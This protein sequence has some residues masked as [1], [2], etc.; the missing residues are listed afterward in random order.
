MLTSERQLLTTSSP[1]LIDRSTTQM[2]VQAH[3]GD[4]N[5]I[6]VTNTAGLTI[7]ATCGRDRT[8]QLFRKHESHLDLL[9]TLDDHLA[10]VG[11]VKFLDRA[12]ILS[13]SSDRTIIVRKLALGKEQSVAFLPIRVI[14]LK[15]SPV[16]LTAVPA[17]P[18]VV[19][20]STLDRQVLRYNVYSGRLLHSFKAS[21]PISG[22]SVIMSSLD[23]H[24]LDDLTT[25]T[26]LLLGVSS[27]DKSI[28]IHEYDTGALL[29][30]EY[31][32]NSVSAIKLLRRF[33][34]GE[35]PRNYLISCSLDGTVM[36]WG[37]SCNLPKGRGSHDTPIGEESPPRH[38]LPSAQP[39]RRILSKAEILDF[40][41]SLA[42]DVDTLTPTQGSTPSRVRRKT[43]RYDSLAAAPKISSPV[44]PYPV[45]TSLFPAN[46]R[47]QCQSSQGHSPTPSSQKNT[48]S[49]RSKHSLL[50]IRPRSK[51][52]ENL[53]DL[54]E[55]G[56]QMCVSLRTFRNRI[57][58]PSV[59]KLKHGTLQEL[60]KQLNLTVNALNDNADTGN[61]GGKDM[62]S[63][64]LD[65]YLAKM[66]DERLAM[67][68]K[69]EEIA[70]VDSPQSEAKALE[71]LV[72][73]S[74]GGQEGALESE[75]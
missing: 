64:V 1:S 22:N 10:A 38:I 26:R 6:A 70:P 31:G 40:R 57:T 55:L 4:I 73:A 47:T 11:D 25:E 56:E 36:T 27:T 71:E 61:V 7:I 13:I 50:D 19:L 75:Q 17:E 63:D 3:S 28:R 59:A 24:E 29:I 67:K 23:V 41:K 68:A 66:I 33:V 62:G 16:S 72:S 2:V 53:N 43:S 35:S 15:A 37:L 44:L 48:L 32:Q 21:D 14:T 18:N 8:L 20:V 5:G 9:Q 45:G 65:V 49:S 69:S 51:S 74:V 60:A 39:L 30:R 52:A 12:T 46:G 54:N 34:E 58:L 42:S